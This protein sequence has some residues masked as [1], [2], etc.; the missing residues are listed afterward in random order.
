MGRRLLISQLENCLYYQVGRHFWWVG[1]SDISVEG[2]WVWTSTG[3]KVG[4]F[5]WDAS[6]PNNLIG[7]DCLLLNNLHQYSGFDN[8]CSAYFDPICQYQP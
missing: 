8:L 3:E 4:D 6:Q 7:Y 5:I 2:G 1:G